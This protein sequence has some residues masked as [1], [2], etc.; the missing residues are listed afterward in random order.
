[1]L[2]LQH[3]L[4]KRGK[5]RNI[6]LHVLCQSKSMIAYIHL[7]YLQMP[8]SSRCRLTLGKA[9]CVAKGKVVY[10]SVSLKNSEFVIQENWKKD[11]GRLLNKWFFMRVTQELLQDVVIMLTFKFGF[12]R[13]WF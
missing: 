4:A 2:M 1:M 10:S 6:S 3:L 13:S 8:T 9:Y 5:Q 12:L 7:S 11:R